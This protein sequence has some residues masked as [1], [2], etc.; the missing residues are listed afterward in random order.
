METQE[1]PQPLQTQTTQNRKRLKTQVLNSNIGQNFTQW[2]C[3]GVKANLN[4]LL[5]LLTEINP[6]IICPQETFLKENKINITILK[7][8]LHT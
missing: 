8:Q 2:R 7:A 1:N 3:R 6:A 4:D 5:L